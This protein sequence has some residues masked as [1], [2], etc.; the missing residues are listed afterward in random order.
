MESNNAIAIYQT[1]DGKVTIDV[2]VKDETIWLTQRQIASLFGTNRQAITKHIK[3][4]YST[5]ELDVSSTSSKMELVEQEGNRRILRERIYYNLDMVLSVGYRV[6]SKNATAFRRWSNTVLKQYL[7]QGYA[8][9]ER[10]ATQKYDELSQLVKVLGRT[11]QNQEQ[12]TEDSRSIF[13]VV[14]DY[15]YA[16]DTLD[17]YDYQQLTIEETTA[18]ADFH[19]T[20]DNA[21]EVIRGLHKSLAVA[22]FSATRR[23][24]LPKVLSVRFIRHL[25][26]LIYIRQSKKRLQCC[27]T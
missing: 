22:N 16:L 15:T 2:T 26:A 14:V 7:L 1:E 25:M 24:T 6:N 11:I 18:K 17:R 21:M 10:V 8:I 4:I 23:M 5:E 9:N 27:Y 19:A 3:N 20:Y 13:D 12:L